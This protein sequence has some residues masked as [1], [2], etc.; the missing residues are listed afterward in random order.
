[1]YVCNPSDLEK[2]DFLSRHLIF[3]KLL[4]TKAVTHLIDIGAYYNPIHLFMA[5]DACPATIMVCVYVGMYMFVCLY[6]MC[7]YVWMN[8]SMCVCTVC[9]YMYVCRHVCMYV[10][11]YTWMVL[12][13]YVCMNSMYVYI[14][15][16]L[17]ALMYPRIYSM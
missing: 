7:V 10:C 4:S 5:G 6:C 9:I 11:M 12:Y 8:D 14:V 1:M 15:Y 17:Y 2:K 13:V 16:V 3:G